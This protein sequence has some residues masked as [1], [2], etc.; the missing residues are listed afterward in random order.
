MCQLPHTPENGLSRPGYLHPLSG[1]TMQSIFTVG[2][3]E[4]D[5]GST[6][7]FTVPEDSFI[8]VY[9]ETAEDIPVALEIAETG[10]VRK[11]IALSMDQDAGES[12][13]LHQQ[14]FRE[15]NVVQLREFIA[16]GSYWIHAKAVN[17]NV[18]V[19]FD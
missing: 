16:A 8:S 17:E 5:S 3:L 13:F 19:N 18:L 7:T 9:V 14:G 12:N 4:L 11:A 15:R 6:I 2:V 10:G 1:H